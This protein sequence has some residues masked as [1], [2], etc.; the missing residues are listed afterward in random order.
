MPSPPDAYVQLP[1]TTSPS[2]LEDVS[3]SF[4]E[5]KWPDWTPNDADMEVIQIEAL[6][7]MGANAAQI[8]AHMPPAALIAYGTKLL[9][10]PYG[11]G[12]PATAE[13]T[14]TVSTSEGCVIPAGSELDIDG[15]AF[16]TVAD[17]VI[18]NGST[19]G[20]VEVRAND[21]GE[22]ANGLTGVSWATV[23][24]PLFVI[25]MTLAAPTGG[26]SDQEEDDEYLSK[27]SRELQ[28]RAKSTITLLD[29]EIVAV[30]QQGVGAA[31][32]VGLATKPRNIIVYLKN[33]EGGIVAGPVKEALAAEYAK[34][35]MVNATISIADALYDKVGVTW[36]A[37]A[38]PGVDPTNL[39]AIGDAALANALSPA[40]WGTP[41]S[42]QPGLSWVNQP[43]VHANKLIQALSAVAGIDYVES[44]SLSASN[45]AELDVALTNGAAIA[46]LNVAS[47]ASQSLG[48]LSATLGTGGA[49]AALP[50]NALPY[51]IPSGATIVLNDGAGH[52]QTWVTTAAAAVGATNVSVTAQVPNFAYPHDTTKLE[53]P[54]VVLANKVAF[55]AKVTIADPTGAHTQ[56]VEVTAEPT[57]GVWT[58]A[59][60]PN[61]NF[62]YP[63][64]SSISGAV[65]GDLTMPGTVALPEAGTLTGTVDSPVL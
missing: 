38:L 54:S 24:L 25:G 14:F 34:T 17:L 10:V 28:L 56:L 40:I 29:F 23:T 21:I 64:G 63:I 6:S 16:Q 37:L 13:A 52:T 15:V 55:P 5:G 3:I 27:V 19:E 22:I 65:V 44:L 8:A 49:I 1:F 45:I 18:P 9:N 12:T 61:A 53:G 48:T 57:P 36:R 20:T 32:A 58:V 42:A 46:S 62:G 31:V 59:G 60:A 2:D 11:A 39:L 33:P 26:G 47:L 4:L 51:A 50:V 35:R 7:P 43:V 41:T 30:D